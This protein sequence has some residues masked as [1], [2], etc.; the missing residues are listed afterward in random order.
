[1]RLANWCPV[2][3]VSRTKRY[4]MLRKM[5]PWQCSNILQ[6]GYEQAA[7]IN[8]TV[9]FTARR[10]NTTNFLTVSRF[11]FTMMSC[12]VHHK[13]AFY[14]A[15]DQRSALQQ[16]STARKGTAA[17]LH[18]A[19]HAQSWIFKLKLSACTFNLFFPQQT[20]PWDQ[21]APRWMNKGLLLLVCATRHSVSNLFK[22]TRD[23]I[24]PYDWR[25]TDLINHGSEYLVQK[26]LC[27]L[28][29]LTALVAFA[30]LNMCVGRGGGETGSILVLRGGWSLSPF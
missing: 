30:D 9:A 6:F 19:T 25:N 8:Q 5:M 17:V 20:G 15:S 3:S 28:P 4:W 21:T 18:S 14:G 12:S 27:P 22:S 16:L 29:S 2:I 1:M 10:E 26:H 24:L 13:Q 7:Q 23:G 11:A